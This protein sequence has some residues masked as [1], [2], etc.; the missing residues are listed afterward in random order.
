M[1]GYIEKSNAITHLTHSLADEDANILRIAKALVHSYTEAGML[2]AVTYSCRRAKTTYLFQQIVRESCLEGKDLAMD[3]LND[4]VS[5]ATERLERLG[6][7]V[8]TF[9]KIN[10]DIMKRS[11]IEKAHMESMIKSLYL[12]EADSEA[13]RLKQAKEIESLTEQ[14]S[15]LHRT[16]TARRKRLRYMHTFICPFADKMPL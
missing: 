16:S 15:E 11:T 2:S 6:T 1:V 10:S 8:Q 5:N 4:R 12:R 7:Q 13:M 9:L 14:I 3:K